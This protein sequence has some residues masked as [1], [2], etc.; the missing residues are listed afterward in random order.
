I[1]RAAT[2]NPHNGLADTAI[3]EFG[4][5]MMIPGKAF[6]VEMG[7]REGGNP[8]TEIS[9]SKTW[10][11]LEGRTFLIE[12]VPLQEVEPQLQQLPEPAG[13]SSSA[14]PRHASASR[15]LPPQRLASLG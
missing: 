10:V 12:E 14:P 11:H 5:M 13:H 15:Q 8:K 4:S 1:H 6:D 9:V 3:L 7:N 2:V